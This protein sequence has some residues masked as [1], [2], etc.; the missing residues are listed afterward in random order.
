M[1]KLFG[2]KS[3]LVCA[4]GALAAMVAAVTPEDVSAQRVTGSGRTP[5]TQAPKQAGPVLDRE[6]GAREAPAAVQAAGLTC[7]ITEAAF[8]GRTADGRNG[9]EVACREGLGYLITTAPTAGGRT[10]GFDCLAAQASVQTGGQPCRLPSNAQPAR[11][12]QSVAA[13]AGL[14]CTVNNARYLG[15]TTS[16]NAVRYEIG[17]AEG[18]GFVLDRPLAA[19][20]RPSAVSCFEAGAGGQFQCQFTTR[21][22]SI[23]PFGAL[24]PQARRQCTL[25]DVRIVGRNPRTQN[26]IVEIGCQNAPGFLVETAANGSFVQAHECGAFANV[27]CQFTS[28]AAVQAATRESLQARLRAAGSNCTIDQFRGIGRE[29]RTGRDVY[30]ASCAGRPDGVLAVLGSAPTDRS[31]VYDCLFA[32]RYG[33]ECQLSQASAVYSRISPSLTLRGR[34]AK[35]NVRNARWMGVTA[36]GENFFEVACDDGRSLVMDYRGNGRVVS[37]FSCRDATGIGGGCRAGVNASAV[38]D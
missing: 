9:Y 25:S 1:K 12:L 13:Q 15:N 11:G 4:A 27:P 10:Q 17:C 37:T 28:Q 38:R 35:C 20:A 26:Q 32:P 3:A 7:T 34:T 22:Q 6:R 33:Q 18:P 8:L 19:G 14:T 5:K 16:T 24:I 23:A 30:E 2:S 21:A 31:E 29:E 36:Q